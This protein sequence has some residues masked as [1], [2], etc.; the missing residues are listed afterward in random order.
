MED[1]TPEEIAE[2][3]RLAAEAEAKAAEEAEKAEFEASLEGLSEE[4]NAAKI[5]EKEAGE[6]DGEPNIDHKAKLDEL[7]RNEKPRSEKE[8]A[9]RALHFNAERLK[10]LGGDPAEVLKLKS[11]SREKEGDVDS[12][13]D[14]KFAERDARA[15]ARTE[16]EY[17]LIMW[18]VDNKKLSVAQAHLL[19]NEGRVRRSA[20]EAQRAA[21]AFGKP[22]IQGKKIT[23]PAVPNRSPEEVA[24]LKKRGLTFNPKTKTYQGKFTEEYFDATTKS[25]Q[26]RKLPK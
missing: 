24:V 3:E 7:E 6:G 15:L 12:V 8:K 16:D 9:E 5:A 2:E 26:S 11:E 19:A 20:I 1:K 18:Y 14:R 4:E 25:W 17:K 23:S 22:P 13:V 21:V 10:E